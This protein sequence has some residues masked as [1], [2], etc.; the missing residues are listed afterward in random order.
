MSPPPSLH[1]SPSHCHLLYLCIPLSPTLPTIPLPPPPHSPS[2]SLSFILPHSPSPPLPL[3]LL[4]LRPPLPLYSPSPPHIRPP[5]SPYYP[6]L[7]V[8]PP[9]PP[10]LNSPS[11]PPL[12]LLHLS[13]SLH[14]LLLH[15]CSR[16]LFSIIQEYFLLH[17]FLMLRCR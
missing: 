14:L 8:L 4:P 12:P 1:S 6:L 10:P 5:H 2:P 17:G 9:P 13:L 7:P 3:V 11:S 16:L 15:P